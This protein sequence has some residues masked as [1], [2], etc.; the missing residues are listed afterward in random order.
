MIVRLLRERAASYRQADIGDPLGLAGL[1]DAMN[2]LEEMTD[3]P[4]LLIAQVLTDIG[5]WLVEFSRTGSIG[6]T[7]VQAWQLLGLVENGQELRRRWFEELHEVEM[8]SLSRRGLT[9]DPSDP[10]GFVVVY[11]TVDSGGRTRDIEVTE[12]S[13]PGFKDSAVIRLMREARFRPRIADGELVSTRRAY[14]FEFRYDPME[15]E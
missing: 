11:F 9:T 13:P 12:S 6:E 4:P 8:S 2:Y 1:Y 3:P 14:R 15:L 10:E 7:Y 5:D